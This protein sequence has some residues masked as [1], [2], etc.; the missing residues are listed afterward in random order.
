MSGLSMPF[1]SDQEQL[2]VRLK[3]ARPEDLQAEIASRYSIIIWLKNHLN[4]RLPIFR[5]PGEILVVIFLYYKAAMEAAAH[6]QAQTSSPFHF[7]R[8]RHSRFAW[9]RVTHVCHHWRTVALDA[10]Q[11]WTSFHVTAQDCEFIREILER[12]KGMPLNIQASL[13]N[14]RN[15]KPV[16]SI[17]AEM[18]RVQ[19]L[20]LEL[21]PQMNHHLCNAAVPFEAP[22]LQSLTLRSTEKQASSVTDMPSLFDACHLPELRELIMFGYKPRWTSNIFAPTLTRLTLSC[23]GRYATSFPTLLD[24]LC[25]MSALEDLN[26]TGGSVSVSLAEQGE[27]A[28]RQAV[29]PKLKHLNFTTSSMKM[30]YVIDCLV[31]PASC[32]TAFC[33]RSLDVVVSTSLAP[34]SDTIL[35]KLSGATSVGSHTPFRTFAILKDPETPTTIILAFW[36]DLL[37]TSNLDLGDASTPKPDLQVSVMLYPVTPE[38]IQEF[39][40]TLPLREIEVLSVGLATCEMKP[41]TSWST[42][43][44]LLQSLNTVRLHDGAAAIGLY[45]MLTVYRGL[46]PSGQREFYAPGMKVLVLDRIRMREAFH[47]DDDLVLELVADALQARKDSGSGVEQLVVKN[48]INMGAKDIEVLQPSVAEVIWDGMESY[49]EVI[50]PTPFPQFR[51]TLGFPGSVISADG[52]DHG[53]CE[54]VEG[55]VEGGSGSASRNV[56]GYGECMF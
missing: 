30:M 48:C 27:I 32:K 55:G 13:D 34:L 53:A 28:G 56:S 39:C 8:A 47:P 19:T 6:A 29:L 18:H 22:R 26:V 31:I 54:E 3:D 11:M 45:S 49:E 46:S 5:L 14:G 7:L 37:P 20:E 9:L 44:I 17:L 4:S 15:P 43:L 16:Q 1:T 24:A 10:P 40:G 42:L 25:R 38:D 12:S 50:F 2:L 52:T 23:W 21:Y 33:L 41:E 36:K 51:Y 35:S